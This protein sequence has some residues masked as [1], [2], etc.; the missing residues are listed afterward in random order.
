[1]K[2][3]MLLII[4][5]LFSVSASAATLTFTGVAGNTGS[6][7]ASTG[8][9]VTAGGTGSTLDDTF[10]IVSDEDAYLTLTATINPFADPSVFIVRDINP[11]GVGA[12]MHI[13]V[14]EIFGLG[15][16][17]YSWFAAANDVF[18]IRIKLDGVAA[19]TDYDFRVTTPIPAAAFLFAPALLGFLGLRRK[20]KSV[21]AA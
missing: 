1:M 20:A 18:K 13:A 5:L 14:T 8:N 2:K 17:T 21:V 3:A 6:V 15:V 19:G 12:P 11:G 7:V 9:F 4:A 16:S 10:K